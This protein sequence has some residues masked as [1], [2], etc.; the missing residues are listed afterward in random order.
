MI[1]RGNI[2][3]M[4]DK[5]VLLNKK[6]SIALFCKIYVCHGKDGAE[7]LKKIPCHEQEQYAD[8][9]WINIE[10]EVQFWTS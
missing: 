1:H 8:W 4:C 9:W 2:G 10:S 5:C 3:D 6:C 7:S